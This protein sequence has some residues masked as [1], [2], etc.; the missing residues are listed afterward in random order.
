MQP[1]SSAQNHQPRFFPTWLLLLIAAV[2][3]LIYVFLVPPW[4]HYDEPGHFEYVWL[5]SRL[6]R[7]PTSEE[8]VDYAFRREV[9]ASMVEHNFFRG[10]GWTPNLIDLED[11]PWIGISQTD[12]QPLYYFLASLP[13]R[14]FSH[15]DVTLQLYLARFTSWGM[16]LFTVWVGRRAA[17]EWFGRQHRMAFL[18]PLFLATLPGFVNLMTAVNN[19][20]G[21]IAFFTLF[22]WIA[23]SLIQGRLSFLRFILLVAAVIACYFTKATA[24]LAIP[25][26]LL[27]LILAIPLRRNLEWLRMV[28]LAVL[29]VGFLYLV[30]DWQTRLP[31]YFY[32]NRLEALRSEVYPSPLGERVFVLERDGL[33]RQAIPEKKL[34]N[35]RGKV[36]TVGAW[37]WAE[38]ASKVNFFELIVDGKSL[39]Q[40]KEIE[41]SEQPQFFH[42]YYLIPPEARQGWILLSAGSLAEGNRLYLDGISMAE[43]LFSPEEVP[44][45]QD[46]QAVRGT[47]GG[48][49]FR[50]LIRNGSAE[51]T[52][53]L[54]AE[55][56]DPIFSR[57]RVDRRY[58]WSLLD[59]EGVGW[60]YRQSLE[61]I[62]R[63]F[64]GQFGW[65]HVPLMGKWTYNV[66]LAFTIIAFCGII[67]QLFRLSQVKWKLVL[68]IT[69]NIVLQFVMVLLRG[70]GSWE[71][72]FLF[73]AARYFFPSFLPLSVSL[74]VGWM[75]LVQIGKIEVKLPLFGKWIIIVLLVL[76]N[77]LAWSSIARF[78]YGGI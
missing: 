20:V 2:N 75:N 26:A 51:M 28:G 7:V 12:D 61:V 17:E 6:G 27:A 8:E 60:F 55:W 57:G 54:V 47:W 58:F 22:V 35:L 49:S 3:G 10:M 13:L 41:L 50:N 18:V 77:S 68:F 25:L 40:P 78:Y 64:W 48:E 34:K 19:D 62:F 59:L 67:G 70:A 38:G 69:L 44:Q 9:A 15:A 23:G 16:F 73:P 52:V 1:L 56:T 21:A 39:G 24:W 46:I 66:L 29:F 4:Q 33:L 36:V 76:L 14:L 63:T 5:L 43:G 65:A 32:T 37:I 74:L 30:F 45:Y 53:P 11:A 72:R 71:S 31:I 42:R